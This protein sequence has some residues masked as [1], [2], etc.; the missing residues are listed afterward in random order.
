MLLPLGLALYYDKQYKAAGEVVTGLLYVDPEPRDMHQALN[1]VAT[2]LNAL[3]EA[4]L[5][6][7][8]EALEKLNAS[9]R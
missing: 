3:R 9:L 2:P 7:G 5:C 4:E 6:P 1:T 8:P